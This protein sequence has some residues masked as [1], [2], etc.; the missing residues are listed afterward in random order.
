MATLARQLS[1]TTAAF[2]FL[3]STS[4]ADASTHATTTKA[5]V[6][7][8]KLAGKKTASGKLYKPGSMTAASKSLPIGS[9]VQVKNKNTGK[10]AIV[11]I[12]DR[13]PNVKGR[14]IDLSR[15]AANTVG[16]KGVSEVSVKPLTVPGKGS[17]NQ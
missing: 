11:T 2:L 3:I 9:K 10:K 4:Q 12:T 13:G 15:K 14:G 16:V 5:S 6:Y 17:K 8:N 7:S 1:L